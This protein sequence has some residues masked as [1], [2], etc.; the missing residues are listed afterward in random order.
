MTLIDIRAPLTVPVTPPGG[1][2]PCLRRVSQLAYGSDN[3][4]GSTSTEDSEVMLSF[5]ALGLDVDGEDGDEWV[6]THTSSGQSPG[7]THCPAPPHT[8]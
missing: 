2:V 1:T 7:L 3:M 4:P 6:A 8:R 5:A